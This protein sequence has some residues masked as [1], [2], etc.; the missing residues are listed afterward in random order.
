MFKHFGTLI[1]ADG[2]S[3]IEVQCRVVQ[4]KAAFYK[5]KSL[6]V[7]VRKRVVCRYI[8][9]VLLYISKSWIFSELVGNHVE[10][11]DMWFCSRMIRMP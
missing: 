3:T 1:T 4:A 10:V 11:V 6:S 2:R 9:P 7:D 5:F 8:E